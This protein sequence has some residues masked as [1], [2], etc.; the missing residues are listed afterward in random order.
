MPVEQ[1]QGFVVG[2]AQ[3]LFI[4][5]EQLPRQAQPRQMPVRALATGDHD[6]QAVGQMIEEKLQ[7]AIKH[8]P[9]G[10]MIVIEHE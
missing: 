3:V 7:A 1:G 4:Q 5:L 9:L 6:Q 8:R 2:Q 10:Q